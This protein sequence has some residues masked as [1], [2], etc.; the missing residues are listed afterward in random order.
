MFLDRTITCLSSQILWPL[1]WG[2]SGMRGRQCWPKCRGFDSHYTQKLYKINN[3]TTDLLCDYCD[4]IL[5]LCVRNSAKIQ[6]SFPHLM[7]ASISPYK[8]A[9]LFNNGL[10]ESQHAIY[11]FLF[12]VTLMFSITTFVRFQFDDWPSSRRWNWSPFSRRVL[13]LRRQSERSRHCH[14]RFLQA[15]KTHD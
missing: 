3:C 7:S 5:L 15:G 8:R 14:V 9:L 13:L 2:S 4:Y 1:G 11:L 12:F 10:V 6:S